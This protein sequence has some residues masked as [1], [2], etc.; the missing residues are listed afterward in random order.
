M[1]TEIIAIGGYEEVGKNMSAV[2]VGKDIVIFDMGIHLDRLHIHEDTYIEKMHSLDLIER[3]VIPDDTLMKDVD[4]KVK[5]IVFTHGHLDHIGAVA[6][7]AHRYDAPLIATPYTMAL[8]ER[9]I[10]GERKFK[11]DNPLQVLN[12]GEKC[13]ISPEIT[14]E[15]VH[16]THSIPQTVTPVLHTSEGVIVYSNDF[17]FDNHQTISPPP[18]YQR[19]RELGE[20][21]VLAAVIDATRAAEPDQVK[22]HS[23]KIARIVL[24]DIMEQPLKEDDGIIITTF[25]SHIERVQAICNIASKSNRQLLLLG[26]SME[27]YCSLAEN[28]GLLKIPE[29]ASVYGSPKAINRALARANEKRSDF[30]LVTTGHQGEPDALL[31]RIAND[32]TLFEVQKGDNIIISAPIIPNPLNKANRNLM[33]RRLKGKGA[34]IF[35]NAHVSGHAGREDHRD[36]LRMLQPQHLI[37]AHGN[38]EM[39]TA[40]AELAE[41]EGYRLGH[42][43]HLLR[44]GQAQ[45]FN[46]EKQ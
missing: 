6:K 35:T 10:K 29:N 27:R 26:R 40:Y 28:M 7:L 8:I 2:K 16:T 44:N 39:L 19:F 3:G 20:K 23:E 5:A 31:P 11:F 12:S 30:V 42:N 18:N 46:K 4:G 21:G 37:P 1:S 25:A 38:L 15:F 34:R 24:E 33:E 22:T 36:F 32:K 41:E 17:K 43:I 9:T 45:V 14:L 13:Q